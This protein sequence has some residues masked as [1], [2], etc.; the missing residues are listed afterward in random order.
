MWCRVRKIK[1]VATTKAI[2]CG[3]WTRFIRWDTEEIGEE[4][5]PV[6]TLSIGIKHSEQGGELCYL[7]RGNSHQRIHSTN[8]TCLFW[9]IRGQSQRSWH[10]VQ[11]ANPQK[12]NISKEE[13]QKQSSCF[14]QKFKK[15][16]S[17]LVARK[18]RSYS[19][20][21]TKGVWEEDDKGGTIVLEGQTVY[22]KKLDFLLDPQKRKRRKHTSI[23]RK[24]QQSQSNTKSLK[25]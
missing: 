20:R 3:Y 15:R 18:R 6:Q 16:S 5:V 4:L 1:M 10:T 14:K 13:R 2:K 22:G 19:V 25:N 11:S 12:S 24:T 23:S 8:R 17:D 21:R 7:P 9:S